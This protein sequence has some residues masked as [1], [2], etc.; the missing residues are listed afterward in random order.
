MKHVEG[1]VTNGFGIFTIAFDS[2]NC[3]NET[4]AIETR[5]R[6]RRLI[7]TLSKLGFMD[8]DDSVKD[9]FN[10]TVNDIEEWG[11]EYAEFTDGAPLDWSNLGLNTFPTESKAYA[12]LMEKLDTDR[13]YENFGIY[14]Y[15]VVKKEE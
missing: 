12:A 13:Q 11:V 3:D 14:V 9:E 1:T 15:R 6:N 7:D 5:I 4:I 10:I 2:D 8:F